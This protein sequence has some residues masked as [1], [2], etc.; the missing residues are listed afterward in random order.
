[1]NNSFLKKYTITVLL[2][3]VTGFII[4][5]HFIPDIKSPIIVADPAVWI[6]PDINAL[7]A[8]PENA[9]I[10]YGEQLI[11]NTA[12]Y[13]G[14]KGNVAQISNGMN[15]GNC[16]LEEG[17]R[18]D[19]NCFA[20]VA[21][22]YPKFKA[23]SGRME[24]IEFRVNDCMERSLNGKKLD[25]LSKEMIA[26]VAYIKWLGKDVPAKAKLKGIGLPNIDLL[27]RA[28]SVNNG[29]A[30]YIAKCSSCHAL[31]GEG[32][33]N[34]NSI[35]YQ[36]PPLWGN[37]SYNISAGMYMISQLAR[38]VKYNMPYTALQQQ[39]TITD[40]EAWDVA[41]FINSQ[42]RPVK[43]FAQDWP[44]IKFKPFDFPFGPYTDTFSVQLH[45]YGPF[46]MIKN[47]SKK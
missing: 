12:A 3:M 19:A 6:V 15:C 23:R 47:Y 8:T 24:S 31:N 25:S 28:A 5:Y 40:E 11:K 30:V 17:T 39:P 45:K 16:H 20:M 10:K 46:E 13:L 18:T 14:P 44:A 7:P 32:V 21:S 27:Q 33:L 43:L 29:R 38:F 2:L 36:Y 34:P 22:S 4:L 1:M 41:A 9:T 35:G 26:I 37:N 42:Q